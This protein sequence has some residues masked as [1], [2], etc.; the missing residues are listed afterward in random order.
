MRL[1][2][3]EPNEKRYAIV[4]KKENIMIDRMAGKI[5]QW[6][7]GIL[8][9]SEEESKVVEYGVSVFL[10]SVFK[11]LVLLFISILIGKEIEFG[12]CL[13]SFCGLRYWAGGIHC[14]TRE[15][16][17]IAMIVLCFIT[18]WT[19]LIIETRGNGILVVLWGISILILLLKAPGRTKAAP[20]LSAKENMEKKI[21]SVAFCLGVVLLSML[22]PRSDWRGI[23]AIA[24]LMES[25]SILPCKRN[26]YNAEKGESL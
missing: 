21:T 25:L 2:K 5:A 24:A 23:V 20:L 10:D 22:L 11:F 12:L 19:S 14:S 9:L 16:C 4:C 26:K 7:K 13:F 6:N 8:K 1:G 3:N 18:L 15:R 17:L